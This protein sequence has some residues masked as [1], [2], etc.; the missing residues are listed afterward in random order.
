MSGKFNAA[1]ATVGQECVTYFDDIPYTDALAVR[2][3]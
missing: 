3:C 2:P 1:N